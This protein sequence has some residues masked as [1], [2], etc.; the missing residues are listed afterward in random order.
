MKDGG[1][2]VMDEIGSLVEELKRFDNKEGY[3]MGRK[4]VEKRLE[5]AV[6]KI[7]QR[8]GAALG[9]LHALLAHEETWSCQYAL[10][11]LKEI[12]SEKSIPALV[13]FIRRTDESEYWDTG[14]DAMKA[15]TAIGEP[16]V[17]P[18]LKEVKADFENRRFLSY[19]VGALTEIKDKRVYAFMKETIEDFLTN[20]KKYS[21][22]FSLEL[23]VHDF[24]V[25]GEKEVLPP[26]RKLLNLDLSQNDRPEVINT[27][28]YLEDPE[29]HEKETTE[30]LEKLK[31]ILP[32][33][34]KVGRNDP[35]PCGSG[36][37]YKHCCWLKKIGVG[38]A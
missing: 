21:G 38:Q 34:T 32:L 33:F 2:K 16:A 9:H 37:K 15:L 12:R 35:C 31:P 6:Q 27:I 7:I 20:P 13:E 29:K 8:G 4:E 28:K 17:E 30:F 18:L 25:Q 26:L 24:G 36:K 3:E 23:F 5:P 19:M 11:I 10:W 22:W 1:K 14:E